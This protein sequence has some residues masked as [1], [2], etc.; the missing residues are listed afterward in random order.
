M[1]ISILSNKGFIYPNLESHI[2]EHTQTIPAL[3]AYLGL[4]LIALFMDQ[5][6]LNVHISRFEAKLV[7]NCLCVVR[8]IV[9]NILLHFV[10]QI[11]QRW[12]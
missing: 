2:L 8:F 7:G 10:P 4:V 6:P 5:V 1:T 11:S 12:W 3:V 9:Q